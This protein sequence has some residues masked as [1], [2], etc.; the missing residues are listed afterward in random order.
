MG[1]H[2]HHRQAD[3]KRRRCGLC[4]ADGTGQGR[5][6]DAGERERENGRGRAGRRGRG[7][8]RGRGRWLRAAHGVDAIGSR[9]ILRSAWRL[10][11][12]VSLNSL[13]WRTETVSGEGSE[14]MR[15][16]GLGAGRPR[17]QVGVAGRAGKGPR[18]PHSGDAVS[19]MT[20]PGAVKESSQRG[21]SCPGLPPAFSVS[22]RFHCRVGPG[23]CRVQQ[24][25]QRGAQ[26]R[27]HAALRTGIT[28]VPH[29]GAI[30]PAGSEQ[31]ALSSMEMTKRR[32]WSSPLAPL[33]SRT[34]AG[35]KRTPSDAAE[36]EMTPDER[37]ERF[38]ARDL[39]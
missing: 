29:S 12:C 11:S 3:G 8:A 23:G 32:N 14:D 5:R 6:E 10:L 9:S 36:A 28:S 7:R 13:R 21:D 27:E 37:R 18:G 26:R 17:G 33:F 19:A 16:G 20:C 38:W 35:V 1:V 34:T 30:P 39:S 25:S 31:R 15:Q 2:T 4:A 24:Q 22:T